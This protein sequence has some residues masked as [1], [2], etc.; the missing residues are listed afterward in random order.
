MYGDEIL[1]YI[2][3]KTANIE[4]PNEKRKILIETIATAI[5]KGYIDIPNDED[6]EGCFYASDMTARNDD[7]IQQ[8]LDEILQSNATFQE[9]NEPKQIATNRGKYGTLIVPYDNANKTVFNKDLPFDKWLP[10]LTS[11]K[12]FNTDKKARAVNIIKRQIQ[13]TAQKENIQLNGYD[14]TVLMGIGN[15]LRMGQK[16][17][18]P[19][20]LYRIIMQDPNANPKP[21]QLKAQDESIR[22]MAKVFIELDV[23]EVLHMYPELGKIQTKGNLV[24]VAG[25][26]GRNANGTFSDYYEF[27]GTP[28]LLNYAFAIGQ[29]A[30]IDDEKQNFLLGPMRDTVENRKI[31]VYLFNRIRALKGK[32]VYTNRINHISFDKLLEYADIVPANYAK[33]QSY[34]NK[35]SRTLKSVQKQLVYLMENDMIESFEWKPEGT[36]GF[37]IFVKRDEKKE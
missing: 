24:D 7:S 14:F 9:I 30:T 28:I 34:A 19:V 25:W 18:T 22:K 26:Y 6:D 21:E 11:G 16:E 5:D 2:A 10:A 17:L 32:K 29:I 12:E 37:D 27:R 31:K 3:S 36:D 20:Q 23:K 4:D 35:K 13:E 15:A 33:K 1:K 8:E